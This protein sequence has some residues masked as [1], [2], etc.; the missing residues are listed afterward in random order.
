MSKLESD[1]QKLLSEAPMAP[2]AD[3]ITVV[4]ILARSPDTDRFILTLANGRTETLDVD[5]V[6]SAKIISG[7]I[8][9]SVVQLELDAKRVPGNLTQAFK[10]GPDFTAGYI[11]YHL[12]P[13]G[14]PL[15]GGGPIGPGSRPTIET[16]VNHMAEV[17]P[18]AALPHHVPP[19][20]MAALEL[21]TGPRTYYFNAYN[22]TS[23]HHTVMK[24]HT[25][26]P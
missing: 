8:G 9:Q 25:D 7:A 10:S 4:G 23:D 22:W 15:G 3:T 17:T 21:F 1:F 20:T 5:A 16:A 18:F 19:A 26:Q 12:G 24:A 13:W 6:K 14:G 2:D 11:D